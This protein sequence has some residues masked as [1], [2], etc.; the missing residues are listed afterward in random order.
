MQ[1]GLIYGQIGQTEYIIR[2]TKKE[3]GYDN[4]KVVATGG[5][6]TIIASETDTIDIYDPT[7]TLQGLRLIYNKQNR[8]K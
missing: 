8:Q 2:Q 1:A 4:L 7:L 6:G 3:T 5:L